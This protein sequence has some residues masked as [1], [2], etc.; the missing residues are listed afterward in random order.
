MSPMT[1]QIISFTIVYSTVYSVA[2]QRKHQSSASMAL[3]RGIHRSPHKG[4]V[5][6]KMCQ[7]LTLNKLLA[8]WQRV[9]F[10]LFSWVHLNPN[11]NGTDLVVL[12]F[13]KHDKPCIDLYNIHNFFQNLM[14]HISLNILTKLLNCHQYRFHILSQIYTQRKNLGRYILHSWPA[15]V[16]ELLSIILK[17]INAYLTNSTYMYQRPIYTY[18]A[19]FM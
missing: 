1:S 18:I 17:I 13:V 2:D 9:V 7:D 10:H 4:P 3:V 15:C 19:N 8:E 5:T 6:R 16:F 14:L 12:I 11:M